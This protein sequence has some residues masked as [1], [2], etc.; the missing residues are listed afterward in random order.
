M[1]NSPSGDSMLDRFVRILDAFDADHPALTVTALARRAA[2][3][4]ATA[5]RLVEELVS[6]GLLARNDDGET[7]LGLRLWEL[8]NRASMTRDLRLV[9][10][11]YMEDINRL[12]QQNT[13]LSILHEEEVLIVERL[14]RPGAAVNQA[15]VAGRMPVL[16]TSMGMALLAFSPQHVIEGF[17]ERHHQ[18]A[19]ALHPDL[20]RTLAHIRLTG[21]ATLAGFTDPGTTGAAVPILDERRHAAAVI[22]VVV[23]TESDLLPAAVMALRTAAGGIARALAGTV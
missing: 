7:R 9:A 1:A 23:P 6:H 3:P 19:L 8:S 11:P 18:D 2:V 20:R 21:Y 22:S 15:H 17:L 12:V 4:R 10:L 14:S 16:R 5:Y 13:Q